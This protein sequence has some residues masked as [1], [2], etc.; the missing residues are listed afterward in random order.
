MV[1]LVFLVLQLLPVLNVA[2][3][4]IISMPNCVDH[5]GDVQIPYPFGI[6]ANCYREP[7]YEIICNASFGSPK[8]F[9]R[10][11]NFEV[12]EISWPGRYSRETDSYNPGQIIT[13]GMP[14]QNICTI[15]GAKEIRSY[16]FKGSPYLY[17]MDYNV[18][19]MEG[20]GGSAQLKN[21]DRQ[22]LAG[23]ASV[24]DSDAAYMSGTT[25]YG[26]GCCQASMPITPFYD[27]YYSWGRGVDF[28]EINVVFEQP[29][30]SNICNA[31]VA[32]IDSRSMDSINGSW[33]S[34]KIFPRTLFWMGAVGQLLPTDNKTD[35]SL[36]DPY[37][38]SEC[39]FPYEGNPYIPNGCQVVEECRKC[40]SRCALH[41]NLNGPRFYCCEKHLLLKRAPFL[42]FIAGLGFVLL[43]LSSYWLYRY[44]KRR[45][46]IKQKAEHFK[47]NG[48]LLLQQQMSSDVG[49]VET[50]KIFTVIELEKATDNFNENRILGQGGQGTVYK[51]MLM[52]GKIVAIKKAKKVDESQVGQFVNEVVILSQINYRNVVKLLGC[53]LET[54]V[55]ILVYEFVP[56]GTLYEHIHGQSEEFHVGWKMRLQ[57]AAESAGAVAYLHSS[58]SAPIY[59]RDIKSTNILLDEKYRAKVSDFG[60]SKAINIDQTHVTTV[61]LGTYG[62]LD[63][64]YFQ[65]NQFTEKSDVYSFG[66]VLVELIA[67]KK[68][69]FPTGDGGWISLATEF[70]T[71][72]EDSRLLDMLDARIIDEGKEDE[73]MAVAKLARKCLNMNGKQRPTMK[74]IAVRL[75]GIRSSYMPI[76]KES[77]PA[78]SMQVVTE[79]FY[80]D[81]GPFGKGVFSLDDD[82]PAC[83][84]EILPLM[85]SD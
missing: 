26:I 70:L 18:L 38:E 44:V 29:S 6:G 77:E 62:Y 74:E 68:P 4:P 12:L 3:G 42:G 25:C 66:V 9:L 36:I 14:R 79:V 20:C 76:S 5:C 48:G 49:A 46:E 37:T 75:D 78:N 71:K 84:V 30:K 32:L 39:K 34:L 27:D 10:D 15:D 57:I 13:V 67:G 47:R 80:T 16:D 31:T 83:S 85:N 60:T 33:S 64:E 65:S 24:C 61:V 28:Y 40:K 45:R 2:V 53:C 19:M 82:L 7:P 1:S 52:D 54:E 59:H 51:G 81:G 69:I 11:S 8:P 56:N 23:C 55:P 22:V 43:V 35:F 58:S 41:Y 63:P 72:M 73:F 21:R 50:T 17:S